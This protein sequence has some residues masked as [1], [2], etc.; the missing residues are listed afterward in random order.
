MQAL[1]RLALRGADRAA[2]PTAAAGGA[3]PRAA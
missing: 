3:A 1:D 2:F